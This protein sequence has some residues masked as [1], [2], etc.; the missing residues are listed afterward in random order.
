[1]ERTAQLSN[2]SNRSP[3]CGVR[4]ALVWTTVMTATSVLPA[5]GQFEITRSTVDGGGGS[6]TGGTVEMQG[7]VGQPDA[8]LQTGGPYTLRGG[9]W[10]PASPAVSP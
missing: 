1:M 7:T 6:S 3:A 2:I 9:F 4:C 10:T 8:G 5:F